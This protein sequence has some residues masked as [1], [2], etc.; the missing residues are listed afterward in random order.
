MVKKE[1]C[2]GCAICVKLCPKNTLAMDGRGKAFVKNQAS[3]SGC[4]TCETHCPDF[5]IS[6]EVK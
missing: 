2:K 6:L 3:C 4:G 5:A 1:Y